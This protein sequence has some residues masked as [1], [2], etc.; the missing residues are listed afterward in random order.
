M[1]HI[2][3]ELGSSYP[4]LGVY[5]IDSLCTRLSGQMLSGMSV[6][7]RKQYVIR[8]GLKSEL[9]MIYQGKTTLYNIIIK[10]N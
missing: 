5:N 10:R 3:E 7:E 8:S 1:E 9:F 4:N 2:R 6:D